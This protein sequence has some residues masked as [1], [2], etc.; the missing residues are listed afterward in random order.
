MIRLLLVRHGETDWNVQRRYQG[1]TDIPLN[2]NGK[3]QARRLAG[4]LR[5]EHIDAVY[6][7]DLCRASETARLLCEPLGLTPQPEPRLRE[8]NFGSIQGMTFDEAHEAHA[9]MIDAW[10]AD[11]NNPPEGGEPL[12]A[13][14]ERLNSLLADVQ[15]QHDD[16]TVLLVSHGGPLQEII[17][18]ALNMPPEGRWAFKLGNTSLSELHLYDGDA[19]LFRLNDTCHLNGK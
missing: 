13:F 8:M 15:H 14:V 5:D 17:R 19:L 1:H 6:A 7:S 9:E 4:Q 2:D 12:D 3:Q 18:I 16:Q 11:P 10:L